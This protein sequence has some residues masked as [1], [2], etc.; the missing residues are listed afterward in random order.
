[1]FRHISLVLGQTQTPDDVL[2]SLD[3]FH[4]GKSSVDLYLFG[5]VLDLM[6]QTMD[7]PVNR[8]RL[9]EIIDLRAFLILRHPEGDLN[10]LVHTLILDGADG[11]DR[12]TQLLGHFF[13]VDGTAVIADLVHHVK[14]QH[15]GDM[16][17]DELQGEVQ[18]SLDVGG[19]HDV[20]DA[21]RL[22]I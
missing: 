20:D 4:G 1:M 2:V 16:Q 17:V 10:Q 8:A 13:D 21:V 12:D 18:I 7:T 11:Q 15:H 5:V 22:L 9:T 14:R 6:I 19:V 3:Q